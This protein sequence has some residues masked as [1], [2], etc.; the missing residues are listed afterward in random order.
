MLAQHVYTVIGKHNLKKGTLV[1]CQEDQRSANIDGDSALS[2]DHLQEVV[3][4]EPA[5]TKAGDNARNLKP[6]G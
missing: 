4:Q 3:I 2:E 1:Q 6:H 5:R